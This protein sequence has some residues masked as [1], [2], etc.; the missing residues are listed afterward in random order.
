MSPASAA[1]SAGAVPLNGTWTI[2]M[3]AVCL[4]SSM[5]RFVA[6]PT[7]DEPYEIFPGFALA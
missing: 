6:E 3:P 5:V 4:K 7:P 2:S 1:V